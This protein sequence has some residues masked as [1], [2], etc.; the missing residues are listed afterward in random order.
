MVNDVITATT[1]IYDV[2][3]VT[4]QLT[5][6]QKVV[7]RVPGGVAVVD[8]LMGLCSN[9]GLE[10]TICLSYPDLKTSLCAVGLPRFATFWY[11]GC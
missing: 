3:P 4:K 8:L 11:S 9:W 2:D 7:S 10:Q 1:T 5:L 6:K